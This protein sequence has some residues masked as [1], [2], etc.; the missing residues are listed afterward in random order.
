MFHA[1]HNGNN[2]ADANFMPALSAKFFM[3]ISPVPIFSIL[4]ARDALELSC[5]SGAKSISPLLVYDDAFAGFQTHRVSQNVT[6]RNQ[7]RLRYRRR[8][9]PRQP[10]DAQ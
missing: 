9:Q 1:Y 2:C 7:A 6:I 10:V 5:V 3:E 4:L 8:I